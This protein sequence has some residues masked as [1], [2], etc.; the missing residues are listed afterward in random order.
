MHYFGD[1]RLMVGK[2][3]SHYSIIE[4]IGEDGRYPAYLKSCICRN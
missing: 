1:R 4:K 2:T 3:E